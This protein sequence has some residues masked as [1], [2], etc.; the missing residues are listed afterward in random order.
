MQADC[1]FTGGTSHKVCQDYARAGRLLLG[2][3]YAI[4]SDGCSSSPDTDVG[5][6]LLVLAASHRLLTNSQNPIGLWPG[7]CIWNARRAMPL[8]LAPTCLDA[9]LLLAVE[10]FGK[11]RIQ[12]AGDGMVVARKQDGTRTVLDFDCGGAPPYLSYCLDDPARREAWIKAYGKVTIRRNFSEDGMVYLPWQEGGDP[13]YQAVFMADQYDLVL[14][15]SDGVHSFRHR[16]TQEPIPASDVVDRIMDFK[17]MTGEFLTRRMRAFLGR[18]CRELGWTHYDD[19][20]VA[21]IYTGGEH[22]AA[23]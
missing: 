20:G 18:E 8:V 6:H 16:E 17:T 13:V 11:I 3:A 12:V 14:L 22:G 1:Y 10:D 19:V 2:Q 9:T 23:E 5:A 21:A 7:E 15:L 4:V